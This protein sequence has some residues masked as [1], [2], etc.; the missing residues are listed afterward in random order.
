GE[1]GVVAVI[2]EKGLERRRGE[3]QRF[4]Q[5]SQRYTACQFTDSGQ[6]GCVA[7]INENQQVMCVAA[8]TECFDLTRRN[9]TA[10]AAGRQDGERA[11][12]NRGDARVFPVLVALR[13]QAGLR[14]AVERAPAQAGEP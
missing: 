11:F 4:G 13:R 9:E 8:E 14:E 6:R 3:V 2:R 12:C 7:A 1:Y 10:G 5:A